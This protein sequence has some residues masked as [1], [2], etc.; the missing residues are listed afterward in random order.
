LRTS[1]EKAIEWFID[2]VKALPVSIDA[3]YRGLLSIK[4][5]YRLLVDDRA[6][7]QNVR[8]ELADPSTEKGLQ[9][10]L[11]TWLNHY[12]AFLTD[13]QRLGENDE[14]FAARKSR[15]RAALEQEWKQLRNDA[16]EALIAV[17][18]IGEELESI[19]PEAMSIAEWRR[20]RELISN[21][22][23]LARFLDRH[24]DRTACSCADAGNRRTAE[25]RSANYRPI[26]RRAGSSHKK[27]WLASVPSSRHL[28]MK[29]PAGWRESFGRP[30]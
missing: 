1:Y 16:A 14:E 20:F 19:A 24:A 25:A 30:S 2:L 28:R 26:C 9:T 13:K 11:G 27:G 29:F 21:E 12:D 4:G 7:L 5:H 22:K 8:R 10:K 23:E 6:R 17:S 15:E 18:R 3:I